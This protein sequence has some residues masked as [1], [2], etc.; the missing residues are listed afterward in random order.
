M[1]GI[2]LTHR[3]RNERTPSILKTQE[4]TFVHWALLPQVGDLAVQWTVCEHRGMIVDPRWKALKVNA[5]LSVMCFRASLRTKS[6]ETLTGSVI[7][8]SNGRVRQLTAYNN[9]YCSEDC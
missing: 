2:V 4:S 7:L 6:G 9:T 3:R 1:A 8:R 5:A